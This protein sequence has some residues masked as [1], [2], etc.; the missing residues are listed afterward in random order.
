MKLALSLAILAILL[1]SAFT[2]PANAVSGQNSFV[3][4]GKGTVDQSSPF[5]GEVIRML[6]NGET[7]TIIHPGIGIE[8]VRMSIVPS[9]A[10]THTKSMLCFDG[11]ITSVKNTNAH[12]IGDEVGLAL[13]LANNKLMLTINTGSLS[14]TIISVTL[15]KTNIQLNEPYTITLSKEGGI[16]GMQTTVTLDTSS[17]TVTGDV[18]KSLDHD[19]VKSITKA[20]KKSKF[21][22][23]KEQY[24]SVEG[25]AD[26][27]T[28][29]IQVSQGAFEKTV[30]WTDTSEQVPEKLLR[31]HDVLSQ[32]LNA[33]ENILDVTPLAIA[34][35]FVKSSPTFAFDG[36]EESLAVKD[37]FVLESFPE[38]HVI[39]IVFDSLHGGYGNRT[40]QMMTQ[41]ITPHTI[42]VTVVD[43]NITSAIMD[44]TW[45]EIN[46]KLLDN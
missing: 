26:Y 27:F 40:D 3:F 5:A 17:G 34:E 32:T 33:S 18:N 1:S 16:A 46:Q 9:D 45:D 14:G 7:A 13:D 28:Y 25:A 37:M 15:S 42:V 8:V 12:Q 4:Y 44:E 41:A 31:L 20:V 23:L 29:S 24:P 6:V 22:D 43:G 30:V 10:C 36:I 39:T 35:N 38:Q 21:F 11:T 2:M 19:S